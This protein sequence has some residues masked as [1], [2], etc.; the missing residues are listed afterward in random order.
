MTLDV[1]PLESLPSDPLSAALTYGRAGFRVLPVHDVSDGVCSCPDPRPNGSPGG[2]R[3]PDKGKH[4]RIG[5]WQREATGDAAEL[6]RWWDKWPAA[7]VGLAMG[8]PE[9]LIALDVDG[10]AG[11]ASLAQLEL[12][13]G[14]LPETLTSRSGRVDGGEHRLFVV[15]IEWDLDKIRNRAGMLGERLD[16]RTEGGQIVVAPSMHASGRA[17]AWTLILPPAELPRWLFD[18]MTAPKELQRAARAPALTTSPARRPPPSGKPHVAAYLAAALDGAARAILEAPRGSFNDTANA[19]A[20]ALGGL[21]GGGALGEDAAFEVL[22]AATIKAG[23]DEDKRELTEGTIRRALQA[24]AAAPRRIP[25]PLDLSTP[26]D[27]PP[28]RIKTATEES[29]SDMQDDSSGA[30]PMSPAEALTAQLERIAALPKGERTTEALAESTLDAVLATGERSTAYAR[31]LNRLSE[32]GVKI[33]SVKMALRARRQEQRAS[34][35]AAPVSQSSKASITITPEELKVNDAAVQSLAALPHLYQRGRALVSIGESSELVA[36]ESEPVR[37][38]MICQLEQSTLRELLTAA[39]TWWELNDDGDRYQAHPP[40]WT[41]RA[42]HARGNSS[43]GLAGIRYL[44]GLAESP[45]L[46]PDGSI[47]STPGWDEAT[48][49]LLMP[50]DV[51]PEVPESPTRVQLCAAR[52]LLLD[53]VRDFPL[54]TGPRGL[55]ASVWIA[56]VLTALGRYAFAGPAPAFAVDANTQDAGKS[57]MADAAS[58]IVTGRTAARTTYGEE[59]ELVKKITCIALDGDQIVLVDNVEKP[60]GDA[61]I[62]AALTSTEWGERVLGSSTRP[63]LPLVATWWITG[64]NLSFK[65][66]FARRCLLVRIDCQEERPAERVLRDLKAY[67]LENRPALVSAALTMLRAWEATGRDLAELDGKALRLPGTYEAWGRL[68][69]GACVYAGLPDP[70]DALASLD[71]AVHDADAVGLVE[72]L[73]GWDEACRLL[74]GDIGACAVSTVLGKLQDNDEERRSSHGNPPPLVLPQLRE[75]LGELC[76]GVKP[77]SLPTAKQVG[78]AFRKLA[79]R[80]SGGRRLRVH[81]SHGKKVWGVEVVGRRTIVDQAEEPGDVDYP[82]DVADYDAAE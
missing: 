30:S 11:R 5:G 61:T 38:L 4:P 21:V 54:E 25:P 51:F 82:S 19:Q 33:N 68:V 31:A 20:Y 79:K 43:M 73:A 26:F 76:S 34:V 17:Y 23:W 44:T 64:T 3:C 1:S 59:V 2:K 57:L 40:E 39:A 49:I 52:D 14:A 41:V 29:E 67:V 47:L 16:V 12:K 27:D 8:G 77:G 6:Q 36:G 81:K 10:G 63:K 13:H 60:I 70:G 7:N 24:G 28:R 15:P 37:R 32:L 78:Y 65:S 66:T 50:S 69:Q 80:V 55:H 56:G 58:L 18:L 35:I 72:L 74:G 53:V 71:D 48:G 46:R 42:V 22:V 9:R 45:V 62:D 75:V